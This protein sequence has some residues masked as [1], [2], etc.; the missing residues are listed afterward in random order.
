[1]TTDY[2]E[3]LVIP[4]QPL[5]GGQKPTLSWWNEDLLLRYLISYAWI[6]DGNSLTL[7]KRTHKHDIA[8]VDQGG[9]RPMTPQILVVILFYFYFY[10]IFG[11]WTSLSR[12]RSLCRNRVPIAPILRAVMRSVARAGHW[13]CALSAELT[14]CRA[15]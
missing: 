12:Q 3:A 15:C 14:C 7:H 5:L 6:V 13:S 4:F 11:Y 8:L 1:M 9:P 2:P 10:I